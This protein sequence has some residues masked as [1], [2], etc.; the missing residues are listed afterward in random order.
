MLVLALQ[1]SFRGHSY[2][3]Y[4]TFD[5]RQYPPGSGTTAPSHWPNTSGGQT[6]HLFSPAVKMTESPVK[7]KNACNRIIIIR[8]QFNA[9][10]LISTAVISTYLGTL[11][12]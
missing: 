11:Y 5:Q 10:L 2:T 8:I 6:P 4:E 9:H 3:P 12:T 1:P 7:D